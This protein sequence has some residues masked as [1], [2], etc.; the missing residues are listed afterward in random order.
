MFIPFVFPN[1]QVEEPKDV[2]DGGRQPGVITKKA[3]VPWR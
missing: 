3:E 2:R 1:P